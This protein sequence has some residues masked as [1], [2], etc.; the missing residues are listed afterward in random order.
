MSVSGHDG[1]RVSPRS[2]QVIRVEAQSVRDA[3]RIVTPKFPLTQVLE[4][5]LPTAV[6]DFVCDIREDFEMKALYGANIEAMTTP[7]RLLI[8]L[9][10]ST[11]DG[12]CREQGRPRFTVAH[13]LGHL[14]LHQK[15]SQRFARASS[16]QIQPYEN[17]EWQANTFAAELLMPLHMA[18]ECT[19]AEEISEVFAVSKE[20]AA[21]RWE[22]VK[23]EI[24]KKKNPE[25]Q[26]WAFQEKRKRN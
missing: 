24:S 26:L 10:A 17:S 6:E 4:V 2:T 7:D 25:R 5:A 13:E 1:F 23:K 18:C 21:F 9:R 3:L 22:L 20:A 14:F 8:E 19:S 16:S 15:E 12:L 11:Y